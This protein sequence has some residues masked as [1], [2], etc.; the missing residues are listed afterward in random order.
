MRPIRM[1]RDLHLLRRRQPAIGVAQQLVDLG[2]KPGDL[3]GDV[4]LAG[5]G[6]VPK[7]LD[8][9]FDLGDRLFEFEKGLH[10]ALRLALGIGGLSNT[11]PR[12]LRPKSVQG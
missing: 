5:V 11:G 7:L 1:P 3:V 2:L 10:T 12:A 4:E 9:A 8:L 6:D